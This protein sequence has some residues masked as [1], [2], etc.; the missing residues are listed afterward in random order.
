MT[1]H[2]A[3]QLVVGFDADQISDQLAFQF[4]SSDGNPAEHPTG[5]FNGEVHF[6]RDSTFHLRVIGSGKAGRLHKFKVVDCCL[7]TQPLIVEA[8]S[9]YTRYAPP[10]P[11][12]ECKG[13]SYC[14]PLDFSILSSATMADPARVIINQEWR[15]TLH[16]SDVRG[17]WNMSLLITVEILR[18]PD[19]MPELRVFSFDPESQVGAGGGQD[20]E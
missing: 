4:L 14:L 16:V 5:L 12:L 19:A 11:F 3:V 2:S 6:D 13:A 10:S 8:G 1:L 17:R 15:H 18:S 20:S 9:N 7:L